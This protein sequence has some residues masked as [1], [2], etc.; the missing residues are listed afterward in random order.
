[1]PDE[2][3]QEKLRTLRARSRLGGGQERIDAQHKRG[4]LTARE[5]LGLLLDEASFVELD[6]FVTH[7]I[8]DFGMADNR[9]LGDG[10][11]HRIRHDRGAAGLRVRRGFHCLRRLAV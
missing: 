1:M 3:K 7:R 8:T 5:R 6:P 2:A 4:K 11:R 10:G 9:P